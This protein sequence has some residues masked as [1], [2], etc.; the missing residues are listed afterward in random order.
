MKEQGSRSNNSPAQN[1]A[2]T[3]AQDAR[4]MRQ[5]LQLAE[6][7]VGMASPNPTVGCVLVKNDVPVGRGAHHYDRKAHAEIMA[8]EDAGEAAR[9]ATA[10][11]TLEPCSH[12]GRTGPCA[13][14]LIDAGVARVVAATGD[15]NPLVHGNGFRMLR[16]AGIP[17][18]VGALAEQARALNDGFARWVRTA[19]PFVTLKAGVSLDGRIAP[20]RSD[21][22]SGH[23]TYLTGAR[24]LLAVQKL[25]HAA[26]AV[27]T[28]V[29]TV[30]EDNPLLTDRSGLPRRRRLLRV[31]LDSELR[32][33]V[34]S[35]LIATAQGDLLIFTAKR[36]GDDGHAQRCAALVKAGAKI[37]PVGSAAL[38]SLDLAQV[39]SRLGEQYGVLNL[40]V[41][42][43]SRLN[44]TLLLGAEDGPPL[45]DKLCLFYAPIFLGAAGVPLIAGD[46]PL[47]LELRRA[48]IAESGLDFRVEAYLRDPWHER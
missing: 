25:R 39:L 20:P 40:L 1:L 29:G 35:Q 12:T 5:A 47:P 17:V 41:E 8:L 6:Q 10:Y 7:A 45:A 2:T 32:L 23:V 3:P 28:G 44:R 9:G 27:L 14:A 18:T 33:P 15:P 42:G 34:S 24:S 38:G 37:E 31:V 36:P 11:V 16:D 21:E 4:W 22:T 13:Q 26:D 48:T 30:L 43:G 19:I 46:A